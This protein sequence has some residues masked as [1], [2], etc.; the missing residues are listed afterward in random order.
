[1]PA[2]RPKITHVVRQFWPQQGGLEESVRQLCVTLRQRHD[3]DV[4]VVTL[5]RTFSDG[6]SHAADAVVDGV[7]VRRLGFH[8]SNRYPV[9]PGFLDA[10]AGAD[11]IHV[12][13]IDFFFDAL[14]LARP[15][16]TMPMV[17]STHGGFFHTAFASRLK[18]L[19]FSTVTRAACR[20]Y[21]VIGASSEGDG[22]LFRPIAGDRVEVIENGVDIGKWAGAAAA[23]YRPTMIAI[24][25]WSSN[26]NME[27]MFALLAALVA[28]DP[29][30]RLVI[31]GNPYDVSHADL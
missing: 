12:H 11:L 23:G 22:A 25:R 30:W 20:A 19:Y 29:A 6:N 16:R 26:K 3:A 9:A 4:R 18:A 31:A 5:D 15:F 24:G 28:A 21:D 7:P 17:A 13:A 8:G 27:A 1:M 10:T 14:A 2:A